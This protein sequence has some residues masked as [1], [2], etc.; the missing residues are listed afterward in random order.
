MP[1]IKKATEGGALVFEFEAASLWDAQAQMWTQTPSR[2]L[3]DD[4]ARVV[5]G[6]TPSGKVRFDVPR[7]KVGG[8]AQDGHGDSFSALL[9]AFWLAG[10]EDDDGDWGDEVVRPVVAEDELPWELED[11]ESAW[12]GAW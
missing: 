9:L 11:L 8:V 2:I 3:L 10:G 7:A 1:R 6:Q 4:M 5:Q 12:Q